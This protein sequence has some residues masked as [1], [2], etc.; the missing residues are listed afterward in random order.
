MLKL[1]IRAHA[2]QIATIILWAAVMI[3]ARRWPAH[4]D[5]VKLV[6]SAIALA[7]GIQLPPFRFSADALT[8]LVGSALLTL[9]VV[10]CTSRQVAKTEYEMQSESCVKIYD[11]NGAAQ[12]SCLDYVRNKW[13]AAGAKLAATDGG[14]Q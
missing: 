1:W 3:A 8:K 14:D 10:A 6:D 9:L 13:T 4:A 12:K 7:I 2:R 11:G 5:D